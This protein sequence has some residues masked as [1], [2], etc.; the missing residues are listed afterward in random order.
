MNYCL[1]DSQKELHAACEKA[2]HLGQIVAL[3]LFKIVIILYSVP[4]QLV[5]RCCYTYLYLHCVDSTIF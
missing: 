2:F 3:F 1:K 5:W 4:S